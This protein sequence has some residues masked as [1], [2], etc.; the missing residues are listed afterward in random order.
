MIRQIHLKRTKITTE[1]NNECVCKIN[2]G[3]KASI[4]SSEGNTQIELKY[5][6]TS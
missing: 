3:L 4:T 1:V 2:E 6:F 5:W